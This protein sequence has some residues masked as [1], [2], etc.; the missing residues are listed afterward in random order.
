MAVNG[1]RSP[2]EPQ[3]YNDRGSNQPID[4]AGNSRPCVDFEGM[5]AMFLYIADRDGVRS[6]LIQSSCLAASFNSIASSDVENSKKFN[7]RV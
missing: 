2:Y 6:C 4:V 1:C 3:G 5:A 7:L